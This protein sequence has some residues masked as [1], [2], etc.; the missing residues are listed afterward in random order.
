MG[1]G[2]GVRISRAIK[3]AEH[4]KLK[5]RACLMNVLFIA[6]FLFIRILFFSFPKI[7]LCASGLNERDQRDKKEFY[8]CDAEN[9]GVRPAVS[10]I[11]PTTPSSSDDDG[12]VDLPVVPVITAFALR[13]IVVPST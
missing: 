9:A 12:S 13:T 7:L 3:P 8:D 6:F 5:A 11:R 1:I 2:S 10:N 4:N